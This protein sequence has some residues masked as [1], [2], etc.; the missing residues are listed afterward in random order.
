MAKAKQSMNLKH[1]FKYLYKNLPIKKRLRG[2]EINES[3][4]QVR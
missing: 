1:N 2:R 4:S 3:I